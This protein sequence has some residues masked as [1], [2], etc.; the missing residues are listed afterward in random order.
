MNKEWLISKEE[1]LERCPALTRWSL[2]YLCRHRRIP[3]VKL[4]RRIYF[5][6]RDIENWLDSNKIDPQKLKTNG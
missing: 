4:G 6:P 3:L 1:L 2:E 5:D